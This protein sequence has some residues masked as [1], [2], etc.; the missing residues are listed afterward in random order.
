[1]MT[2]DITDNDKML[3]F[4]NLLAELNEH[5]KVNQMKEQIKQFGIAAEI[6]EEALVPFEPKM[7][8]NFSKRIKED[9]SNK[10]HDAISETIGQLVWHIVDKIED[11]PQQQQLFE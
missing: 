11:Q 9:G 2:T 7:L 5:M 1:M 6:F 8:A 10:L 3:L 4:L